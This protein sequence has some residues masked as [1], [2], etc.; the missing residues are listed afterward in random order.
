[1]TKR[2]RP[3][4][5]ELLIRLFLLSVPECRVRAGLPAR[6]PLTLQQVAD[7]VGVSRQAI[8]QTERQAFRKIRLKLAKQQIDYDN[9]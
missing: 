6:G 1:M 8:S 3:K 7:Y 9:Q 5:D 4:L 2:K